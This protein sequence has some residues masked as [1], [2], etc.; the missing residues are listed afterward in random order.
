[1]PGIR[2]VCEEDLDSVLQIENESFKNPWALKI[3]STLARWRGCTPIS[4]KRR[5]YM[6]VAEEDCTVIGYV[7]WE[8]NY[9][10][11]EGRILNLAVSVKCQR[12]GIG[13]TLVHFAFNSMRDSK[14]KTCFLEARV[15]NQ[16]ARALYENL[17][18]LL[19]GTSPEYYGDED[20]V[21]Y[22][23]KLEDA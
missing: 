14:I 3:F 12:R 10:T 22:F 17:G 16:P 21:I 2:L 1:M 15:S 5:I 6:R 20:A 13:S 8:E 23:I 9:K 11:E 19:C 4:G 18:M 7:V